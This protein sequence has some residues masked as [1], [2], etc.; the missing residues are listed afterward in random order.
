MT[1]MLS[2]KLKMDFLSENVLKN[3]KKKTENDTI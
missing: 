3:K 1:V 2:K